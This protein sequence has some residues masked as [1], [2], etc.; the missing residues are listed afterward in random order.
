M[1]CSIARGPMSRIMSSSFTSS[2]ETTWEGANASNFLATTASTGSTIWHLPD[3]ALARISR[4]VPSISFSQIDL[5][6]FLPCAARKVLAMPPPIT[7][8]PPW[9]RGCRAVRSWWKSSRRPPAPRAGA[10]ALRAPCV[11]RFDFRLHGAAGIGRKFPRQA[12]G[13]SVRA[14]RGGESVVDIEVAELRER[15]DEIRRVLFLAGMEAGVFEHQHV[16]R[17]HRRDG[18]LGIWPDAILREGDRLAENFRDRG[19]DRRQRLALVAALGPAEMRKQDRL[20]ALVRDLADRR[21]GRADARVVGHAPV[22]HRHVE[23]DAHQHAL[24]LYVGLVEGAEVGHSR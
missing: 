14:M 11:E 16:A 10:A 18:L 3:F 24:V 23:I 8:N 13:R 21:D 17:L 15:R 6:T 20:A 22:L 7:R 9:R 12:L 1:N 5:P 2:T 19:H 4:A